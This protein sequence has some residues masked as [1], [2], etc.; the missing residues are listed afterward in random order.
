MHAAYLLSCFSF[1]IKQKAFLC[2]PIVNS[3]LLNFITTVWFSSLG[4][5]GRLFSLG[6]CL[7]FFNS[8]CKFPLITIDMLLKVRVECIFKLFHCIIIETL[9]LLSRYWRKIWTG[10]MYNGRRLGSGLLER[11]IPWHGC[12]SCQ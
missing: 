11:N 2:W 8:L 7:A 10:K 6:P 9:N 3:I 4:D 12:I 1:S 5:L